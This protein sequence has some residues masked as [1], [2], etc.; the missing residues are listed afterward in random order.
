MA[1]SF[2]HMRDMQV[3]DDEKSEDRAAMYAMPGSGS[4]VPPGLCLCLT[5][6]ELDKLGKD[7]DLEVGDLIHLFAMAKVTSVSKRDDGDGPKCRLELAI[8]ALAA[9]DEN[10]EDGPDG[11]DA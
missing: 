2:R 11:D 6:R 10:D 7:A 9:E 5:E 3:T 4:A 8:I 1:S